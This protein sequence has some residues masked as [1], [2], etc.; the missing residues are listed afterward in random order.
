M[1]ISFSLIKSCFSFLLCL[2]FLHPETS[3]SSSWSTSLS[4]SLLG[5]VTA[6][7][8]G[9]RPA[10]LFFRRGWRSSGVV[11]FSPVL[12]SD[13]DLI[14]RGPFYVQ[15]GG[16]SSNVTEP[17]DCSSVISDS[18]LLAVE[19]ALDMFTLGM[20]HLDQLLLNPHPVPPRCHRWVV[21][22]HPD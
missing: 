16:H 15:L 8:R 12:H 2:T 6:V 18:S 4:T 13:G 17:E 20:C 21:H 19:Y 22:L 10:S 1:F 9:R 14:S 7:G 11:I 3:T 5:P